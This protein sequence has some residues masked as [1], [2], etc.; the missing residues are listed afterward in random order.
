MRSWSI[1]SR[2][3]PPSWRSGCSALALALPMLSLAAPADAQAQPATGEA[4]DQAIVV[5]GSRLGRGFEAPTPVT[6]VGAV[7]I[8]DRAITSVAELNYE[9]PQLRVNQNVGRS[10]E[11]VGQNQ[12]DLR[13]LGAARTLVLLD[14]RRLAATSPFGGIDS[15]V[16][17]VALISNVDVVTGGASAA[18]GSDAVAGVIN[19]GLQKD[20]TGLKLDASYG[21]SRYGDFNRP[22]ISGAAGTSLLDDRLHLEI[23]GDFYHNTGQT[24]QAARPWGQNSPILFGNPLATSTNSQVKNYIANNGRL[25]ATLG[26]L[27]VGVNADTNA[28]NGVD[29]LRGVQFG[30][31]GTP[32]SFT[33]GSPANNT[34]MLGGDGA[35]LEDDGNILPDIKRYSGYGRASFDISPAITLW[36]DLLWSRV[37]VNSDLAPNIDLGATP[38]TIQ[39]DNAFLPTS[40]RTLMTAN[41]ITRFSL[42]RVNMEDGFS[43]NNSKGRVLRYAAG[44]NGKFGDGWEWDAFV[45]RS[46][47]RF[48]QESVNNRIQ[49]N[50][51][52]G[53]DAVIGANG[54][55]VCR[56]NADASTAN[57]NPACVPINVFGA[58]SISQAA[59]NWYRGTSWYDARMTQNAAG[60]NLRGKPFATWAGDVSVAVGGEYRHETIDSVSDALSLTRSWRSINQQPFTGKLTVKEAYLEAAVPLAKDMAFAQNLELNGAVRY[61]DYSSS[62][63]VTTWKVGFNYNPIKDIRLR[64]TIS[65]DIR[66]A[67]INELYAG[68]NQV[69]N[70]LTDPRANRPSPSYIILQLTG[71][72]PTLQPE[73]ADTKS[74][75]LVLQPSFLPGL[76]ASIDYYHIKIDGV[77]TAI[78]SQ[79]ILN[80]CYVSNLQ[81]SCALITVDP[82]TNL[83]SKVVATL[84]NTQRSETSGIDFEIAYRRRLSLLGAEGTVA[85]RLLV[86]Y[87]DKLALT[88]SGLTTSYI[89]DL[90]TDYSGQPHWKWNYDLSWTT[91][92]M[93][94][95]AYFRYI[96]SGKFRSF[97]VDNVDLPADQNHVKGRGYLDLS[98]SYKITDFLE[99]YGKVDN[100]LDVSPPILPNAI[101]QPTVANS[102]M[103]DKVG[104]YYVFGARVRF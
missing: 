16:F 76:N 57:D 63:G 51:F 26:G 14:G 55:P 65:R 67:N 80:N 75:G 85:A 40:I 102:Q 21:V 58:G 56:I 82:N 68:Q 27:I 74:I 59:L 5:T 24:R 81:D 89:G 47:N 36:T 29:V 77:I 62:G 7:Q 20:F 1:I 71:G 8:Q 38:L 69:L 61:A 44:L 22:V 50:W 4:E 28:A 79:T 98:A 72:N 64:G 54:Q 15:N 88:V 19:F 91:D 32:Q 42:G 86:N 39:R 6:T 103:F 25:F 23:A 78:P 41:N 73:R 70:S 37:E 3:G 13:A 45:Q 49:T 43:Q 10:S 33:Y 66:A 34:F 31:G 93:R 95:G 60:A 18:Y 83:I 48:R 96:G 53:V 52:N 2:L 30:T 99:I 84:V 12:I 100:L 90:A 46:D 97:Y 17:P 87:V 92:K 104:R 11:P 94:L 35:S 101:T 9:I